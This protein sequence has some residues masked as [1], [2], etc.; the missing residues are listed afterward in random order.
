MTERHQKPKNAFGVPLDDHYK[1]EV[2][3]MRLGL[4]SGYAI[5]PGNFLTSEQAAKLLTVSTGQLA[6]WRRNGEGPVWWDLGQRM[7]RYERSLL[8]TWL[9]AQEGY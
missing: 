3:K 4:L 2:W 9:A 1:R 6:V 8:L 5:P 7:I